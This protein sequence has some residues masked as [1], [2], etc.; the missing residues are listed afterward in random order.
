MRHHNQL[1]LGLYPEDN[2]PPYPDNPTTVVVSVSG[3]LDSDYAALWARRRWPKTRLILWHA[4]LAGM[5][6]DETPQHLRMLAIA[7]G[8]CRLVIAQAVYALTGDKTPTGCN[9]TTLRRVHIV[10][11]NG[12]VYGPATDNDPDAIHGLLDFARRARLGQPP[13]NKLRYC[14]DYFK[15]RLFN[16]WARERR[17]ELGVRSVLLSGERWAESSKRAKVVS[18]QWRDAI[19]LQSNKDAWPSGW[20]ILWAR[21]GINLALYEVVQATINAGIEPHIGYFAQGETLARLLDPN[22][23]ETARAR[24][25]CRCCIFSH[26]HHIQHALDTH[27]HTM[28]TAVRD[29]LAYEHETGYTWQ[30]RGPLTVAPPCSV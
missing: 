19:T 7:L 29:V 14:T 3:G 16:S 23:N 6:W 15:T 22:R 2:P 12:K 5:D 1:A 21:P 8:N 26:Q 9:A 10:E 13:T 20:R 30:Q 4:H 17:A 27:P 18:W 11:D 25:S 28:L 24:L